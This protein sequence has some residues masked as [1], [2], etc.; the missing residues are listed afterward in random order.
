MLPI[1]HGYNS[2]LVLCRS[3]SEC[4]DKI[5]LANV[6][7]SSA[8][9]PNCLKRKPDFD[10]GKNMATIKHAKGLWNITTIPVMP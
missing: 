4:S 7:G 6:V 8:A 9:V 3:K 1:V 5:Q 2:C 10:V